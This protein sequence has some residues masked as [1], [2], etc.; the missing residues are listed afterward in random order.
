MRQTC[1]GIMKNW[2]KGDEILA[3]CG[4]LFITGDVR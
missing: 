3:T 4:L 1:E 2:G